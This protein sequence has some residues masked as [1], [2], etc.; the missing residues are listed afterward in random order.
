VYYSISLGEYPVSSDSTKRENSL[1]M[2]TS[3]RYTDN[4]M[5]VRLGALTVEMELVSLESF[6][7]RFNSEEA[8]ADYLFQIK[9]P[10]GFVC[11]R[12][13]HHDYYK[14][15]T[16]RLPLYECA[17]CHH[18]ASLTVDTVM[19]GSRTPLQ[20]W[21]IAFYHLS[22][23]HS[24]NA[25]QLKEEIHVTYKTAWSMLHK[26][27]HALHEEDASNLLSGWVQVHDAY[28]GLEH[29][30]VYQR[31]PKEQLLLL[32]AAMNGENKPAY[33]KMKLLLDQY[34]RDWTVFR[35]EKEAFIRDHVQPEQAA[36]VSIVTGIFKS[37]R[38]KPLLPY[39]NQAKRWIRETFHGLSQRHLQVY[40]DEFCFRINAVWKKASVFASLIGLCTEH[41]K[42]LYR[43]LVQR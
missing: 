29:N 1:Y 6:V 22:Q 8:C 12:C 35:A 39:F 43:D 9:W 23:P 4:R 28:Y 7:A 11:P 37:Q 31:Q 18:Q 32:G 20:K 3:V 17:H 24:I 19:E 38:S 27:R 5:Y 21:F 2:G 14:M 33:I 30:S 15:K 26:I 42:I 16:R 41:E 13:H 34:L 10:K 25:L 36:Q 40:F